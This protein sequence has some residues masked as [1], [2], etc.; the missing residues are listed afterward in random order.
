MLYCHFDPHPTD[1]TVSVP[2][3]VSVGEADG[4]VTVCATL[5]AMEATERDFTITLAT[6]DGTG[7]YIT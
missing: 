7:T 2:A 3:M 6:E 5:T 4:M 1:V